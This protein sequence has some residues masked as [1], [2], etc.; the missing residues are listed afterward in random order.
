VNW[1][2]VTYTGSLSFNEWSGSFPQDN[3][4]NFTLVRDDQAGTVTGNIHTVHA[5]T[6]LDLEFYS[7]ETIDHFDTPFWTSFHQAVD[8]GNGAQLING[9]PAVVVGLIGIDNQHSEAAEIHPVL[10]MA[11]R[12]RQS[13]NDEQW[14][15]FVRLSG[16]EGGCSQD[17]HF[18]PGDNISFFLPTNFP[19]LGPNTVFRGTGSGTF[20]IKPVNGGVVLQVDIPQ[21]G[22]HIAWGELHLQRTIGRND[23]GKTSLQSVSWKGS[24]N[25]AIV[26]VDQDQARLPEH[27]SVAPLLQQLTSEQRQTFLATLNQLEMKSAAQAVQMTR[28]D[29]KVIVKHRVL[30]P[31]EQRV[32]VKS[33]AVADVRLKVRL[34]NI[35]KA[36]VKAVG[37]DIAARGVYKRVAPSVVPR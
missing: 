22:D 20:G 3:D 16:N 23:R 32:L 26:P 12:I 21:Q 35:H 13:A 30:V 27:D 9:L 4:Y 31:G 5:S 18:F 19:N 8:T 29:S 1:G 11:V 28:D 7:N 37:S 17:Q 33:R 2:L 15:I 14:A 10:A 36:L 24:V 25:R 6:A 34:L